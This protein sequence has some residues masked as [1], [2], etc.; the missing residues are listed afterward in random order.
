LPLADLRALSD[1]KRLA[2]QCGEKTCGEC[3][4]WDELPKEQRDIIK[5]DEKQAVREMVQERLE[6]ASLGNNIEIQVGLPPFPGR[7]DDEQLLEV[8]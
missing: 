3:I 1:L 5:N 2:I 6:K 8:Y 4:L 7:I